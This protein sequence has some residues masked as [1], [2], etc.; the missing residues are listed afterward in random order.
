[1]PS[2]A[3]NVRRP[4]ER[5]AATSSRP[6]TKRRWFVTR[7]MSLRDA[8][9]RGGDA[10]AKAAAS[11]QKAL[12]RAWDLLAPAL[13]ELAEARA[14]TDLL[15]KAAPEGFPPLVYADDIARGAPALPREELSS[16][17]VEQWCFKSTGNR[18]GDQDAVQGGMLPGGPYAP[19]QRCELRSFR[20]VR[21]S[22][23]E[24]ARYA[25]PISTELRFP[26]WDGA[27]IIFDG[28]FVTPNGVAAA[29]AT[30]EG[31]QSS[32]SARPVFEEFVS[33]GDTT[34]DAA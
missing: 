21:Y 30:I 17:I 31:T 28:A 1:M 14:A 12:R 25:P 3:P 7:A 4:C 5:N 33:I 24:T 27:G 26:R 32:K 19:A 29:L 10:N 6:N 22:P 16:K 9:S 20:H 8:I 23:A 34:S 2:P 11:A 15:N 18:V 13:R